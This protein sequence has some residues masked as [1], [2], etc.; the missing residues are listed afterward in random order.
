MRVASIALLAVL[1]CTVP[2]PGPAPAPEPPPPAKQNPS[3]MVELTR[4][5]ERVV[6]RPVNGE[7]FTVNLLTKP[8]DVLITPAAQSGAEVDLLIH[9]HGAPW[10]VMQ[11]A[12]DSGRPLVVAAVNLGAGSGRYAA[13]FNDDTVFA[14]LREQITARVPRIRKTY[15]TG[16]SAGYGAIREIL[17]QNPDAIDG[18]L[19][20]DGLHTSYI[21]E[22]KPVAEGGTLDET[23]LAPFVRFAERAMRGEKRF[24]VTHSE[25]F[26]G[27]FA[28][29]TETS[30]YL[31]KTLDLKR[32]PV[33]R[34]GPLG[35]QQLSE[36]RHGSFHVLGFA[37]NSAP[38][39]VDQFH[40][41]GTFLVPLFE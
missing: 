12:E 21:P 33:V 4:A 15:L 11:A 2:A 18:V 36:T 9:F 5:H 38:D 37:G 30:D 1:G 16:F 31:L 10:L 39:H 28:S 22:A 14:N 24:I 35:M 6:Q 8:V 3:P 13:A 7:R 32:T 34:W 19:L 17:K 20:I 26:P 40:A 27:T 25:I 41:I 29:T 23:N